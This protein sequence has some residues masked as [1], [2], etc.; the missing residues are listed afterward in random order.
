MVGAS[1][2]WEWIWRCR[3]AVGVKGYF[4]D[5]EGAMSREGS[6]KIFFPAR[7]MLP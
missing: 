1:E 3:V 7:P 2:V 4:G 5:V 6:K